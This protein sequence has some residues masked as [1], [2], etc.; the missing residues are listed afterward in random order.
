MK[1][2]LLPI[3]MTVLL[4]SAVLFGGWYIYRHVGLST[5]LQQKIGNISGV[6]EVNLSVTNREVNVDLDLQ[7][8][9]DL[10]QVYSQLV[11]ASS[12][13]TGTR[14][15]HVAITNSSSTE[16][17]TWWANELFAVAQA[18]ETKQYADIPKTL[19]EDK[20]KL[21]GLQITA[22]MDDENVYVQLK[23][24]NASKFIVLPRN[25]QSVGVFASE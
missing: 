17:D 19:N 24:A 9:A 25:P 23:T 10:R 16:L 4:S 14:Q 7:S 1:V 22:E 13:I 12:K 11:Q 15:L 18:M 2:R 21:Q 5:P 3:L 6:K 20:S 8:N